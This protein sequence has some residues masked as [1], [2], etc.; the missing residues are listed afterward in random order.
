MASRDG[1]YTG[2]DTNIVRTITRKDFS[3]RLGFD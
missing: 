1:V 3:A 2:A